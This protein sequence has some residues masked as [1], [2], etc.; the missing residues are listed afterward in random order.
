MRWYNADSGVWTNTDGS[1][2]WWQSANMLSAF[3]D[4]AMLDGGPKDHY[5]SVWESTF[6]NAPASNPSPSVKKR[7]DGKLEKFYTERTAEEIQGRKMMKRADVG[8]TN[9][10]Y[11][12]EGWWALAWLGARDAS[13]DIKYLN[14]A[15]DIWYDMNAGWNTGPCGGLPWNKYE[16]TAP[17]A[18]ANG[19]VH[20]A[21]IFSSL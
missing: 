4:L 6:N 3:N 9:D 14:E 11:D 19:R 2:Y 13:G 8:F 7:F 21:S 18:I 17:V 16:G 20:R 12:D 10:F 5:S 1:L 15:I